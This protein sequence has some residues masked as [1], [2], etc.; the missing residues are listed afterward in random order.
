LKMRASTGHLGRSDPNAGLGST[1]ANEAQELYQGSAGNA[2]HFTLTLVAAL[3]LALVAAV[4]IAP[5]AAIAVAAAGFKFPFPR[6]FDRVVT[7][8]MFIAMFLFARR[9][10]LLDLL[11]QGFSNVR[12]GI[13]QA[14]GGLALAAAAMSVLFGLVAIAGGDLRSPMIAAAIWRYL[15]AAIVIAVIEE[16]FFRA[17]LLAGMRDELGSSAAVLASS[18]IFA[19]V[20]VIR[21]SARFYLTRF[22]PMAGVKALAAYATRLIR[23][24]V[25]SSILGLFLLG[26]VLGEAFVLTR[27]AY[28]SLGLH[29]GFVLGAKAWRLAVGGIIPRWLAGPGSVPVIAAPAAWVISA[30]MLMMLR[31]WLGPRTQPPLNGLSLSPSP[32]EVRASQ[33]RM[34]DSAGAAYG[35]LS[36]NKADKKPGKSMSGT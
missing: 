9:L 36:R 35:D 4:I 10:K 22:E 34:A 8:A 33:T 15:P 7:V 26:L 19:L 30:F 6:I 28:C 16:S 12:A 1:G 20:H 18:A 31:L 21:S 29:V 2:S 25:G 5:L 23:P 11:R 13:W 32:V 3:G 14:F 24:E 17:F 27:R